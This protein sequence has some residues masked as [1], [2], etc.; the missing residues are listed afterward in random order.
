MIVAVIAVRVVEVSG[1]QI[2]DVVA[3]RHRLVAAV[4]AVLMAALVAAAVV[5]GGAGGGVRCANRDRMLDDG[6]SRILMM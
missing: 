3:M 5:I 1:D 6:A 4:V 2:V